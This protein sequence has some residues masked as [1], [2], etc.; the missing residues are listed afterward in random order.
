MN[1]DEQY[2]TVDFTL[3]NSNSNN[4]VQNRIVM[5]TF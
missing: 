4:I 2:R 5:S 3:I 1:V